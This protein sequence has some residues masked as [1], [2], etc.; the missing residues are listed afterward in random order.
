MSLTPKEIK[1]MEKTHKK[2]TRG[3]PNGLPW[4]G[5]SIE[6]FIKEIRMASDGLLQPE[7]EFDAAMDDP[8]DLLITGWIPKTPEEIERDKKRAARERAKNKEKKAKTEQKELQ[9]IK[10]LA[11]KHNIKLGK[12]I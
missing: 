8:G 6:D 5:V 11:K 2:V 7:I 12:E 10:R 4:W 3:L 9:E 1:A